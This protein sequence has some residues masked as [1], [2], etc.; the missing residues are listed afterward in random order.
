MI[1]LVYPLRRLSRLSREEFQS[2]WR[3]T[4]GPL[5]ARHSTTLRIRRYVQSH[6]LP[7]DDLLNQAMRASRGTLEPFDGVAD[8]WWDDE[9]ELAA[10][11]ATKESRE[12]AREL[13]EDERNFIDFSRSSMWLATEV[14]QV[15]P[16]PENIVARERSPIVKLCYFLHG[17]PALS[18]E[19]AQR[20]WR[21][22][23]GPLV[24][25]VA[26]ALRIRRYVQVHR[27]LDVDDALRQTRA[28]MADPFL[29]HAELWYDRG[30]LAGAAATPEGQRGGELLHEDEA[31]VLDF[32]RSAVWVAKEHTFIDR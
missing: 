17:L 14:P 32:S 11:G 9:R 7:D 3:E 4:H 15:N 22:T 20:Y 6:T 19:E 29:G 2:Y 5:V 18:E 12:A 30:E 23:H 26:Q 28:P 27:L 13:L 16:V 21:M 24:R 25:S 1:R 10:S 8:L 31:R